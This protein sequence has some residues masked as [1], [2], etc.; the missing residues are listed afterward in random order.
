M[1]RIVHL[2]DIHLR[3]D[4]ITDAEEFIIKAL[5]KDLSNFNQT[6]RI[7]LIIISGDLIDKGGESFGNNL[8]TAF[9]MFEE[10][11]I[12]PITQE[13]QLSKHRIF[14][15]PGNH[16]IDRKSDEKWE[17]TGL[18]D[19]LITT[20]EVNKFIDSKK[21]NGIMRVL[22]F[23]KFEMAFYNSFSE[24][25]GCSNYQ[26]CFSLN[27]D[28]V[29][30]GITCFNSVWR[31]YDANTDKGN[32][33]LGERQVTGA[34][35]FIEKCDLK[36]A[37]I[38]HPL[39]W[40]ALFDQKDVT[41][42]IEKD[43]DLLFCGHI[44]EPIS[45]AKT[46]IYG[47]LFVS[48]A[49]TNWTYD[50]R[51]EDKCNNGYSVVDI[52]L[53]NMQITNYYRRYSHHKETFV[54]NTDLGDDRGRRVFSLPDS[55]A[56]FEYQNENTICERI[57]DIFLKDLNRH[58]LSFNTD[59]KAPKDLDSL[60]VLP[61]IVRK[62]EYQVDKLEKEE[63]YSLE[64][65]CKSEDNLLILGTKES[66]KTVLLDK[67]LTEL[68]KNIHKYHKTPV[69]VNFDEIGTKRYETIIST[70]LGIGIK[71]IKEF[72]NSAKVILLI[73]D[74][75]F[76]QVYI[77]ELKR[78]ERFLDENSTVRII[79]T[80]GQSIEGEIPLELF[81]ITTFNRF[82]PLSIKSYRTKEIK[83]LI[84]R[85]FSNNIDFDTPEKLE[86]L[87]TFFSKVNIPRTPLAVSMFLWIIEHQE[88][89]KPINHATLL[90]NFIERLFKK[91]SKKEILA[92]EFDYK[93]KERLLSEIAYQ[94]YKGDQKNYGL[95][96]SDLLTFIDRYLRGR[97]FDFVSEEV[98]EHFL[99]KGI[100]IKESDGAQVIVRFR[101][102]CFFEFFLARKMEFE[103]PFK[104]HVL[105]EENYLNFC[106]EIDYYTGLKRDQASILKLLIGRMNTAYKEVIEEINKLQ[107]S[108]D[109]PFLKIES[110]S[111]TLDTSFVNKL[112]EKKPKE[113]EIEKMKDE[114]L[115]SMKPE[116]GIPKKEDSISFFRRMDKMLG[117]ASKVLKNSEEI[118]EE[119]VK[120]NSYIS[121]L[122]CMMAL[123]ILYKLLIEAYVL[124]FKGRSDLAIVENLKIAREF[125]P[126]IFEIVLF[127]NMGTGKLSGVIRDKI[128][129]DIGGSNITD[130]EK[131]ISIF[132]YSDIRG[133]DY[134]KY[135]KAFVRAIRRSYI[136]DMSLFKIIIYYLYRSRSK[137]ED[138][139]YENIIGDLIV[140]AKGRKRVDKGK[141]I[142]QYKRLKKAK[143]VK[144]S[145]PDLLV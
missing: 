11:V 121:I 28:N 77:P 79:A 67:I 94:M 57:K 6:K 104:E 133:K 107:F 90:E 3:A 135:I 58:L 55:T 51:K 129:R 53:D 47:S 27:V 23:K 100:L 136:V 5:K 84:K 9:S 83:E 40:L 68:T 14:L 114:V 91:L 108:Y 116:T 44:H 99:T 124:K 21:E 15:A 31:S 89:Y 137:K 29:N 39:D 7:D 103:S 86:K 78:L 120:D 123:S 85:W 95:S 63:T 69:H 82:K 2:S 102:A 64:D 109:S 72:L 4:A 10:K 16:D 30:I 17:E 37:V 93:N 62:V 75:S 139:M 35:E 138:E 54:P 132:L 46:G 25:S 73:D 134:L 61:R 142:S 101:F 128:R 71:S 49:P 125:M 143:W 98:L 112:R 145:E 92:G 12:E 87:I 122:Q 22:S 88:D 38:H 127:N 1:I 66:G 50:I 20:E 36:I 24:K 141:I 34:R 110:L 140:A 60:F 119:N 48:I 131:F 70:F 80:S 96:Y 81:E 56:R 130:Y 76:N 105:D 26:S 13:I 117:L 59:T 97:K 33:I 144:D 106:N 111:S 118:E 32:L 113:E 43:Y 52:D 115:D 41:P 18:R 45:W 126:L 74:L 8:K 42:F 19:T 65:L